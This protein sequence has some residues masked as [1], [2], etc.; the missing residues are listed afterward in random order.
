[1]M[2]QKAT[3]KYTIAKKENHMVEISTFEK[4][5]MDA[6]QS[7]YV[8]QPVV[9]DFLFLALLH[10]TPHIAHCIVHHKHSFKP[11][12]ITSLRQSIFVR[13]LSSPIL[14]LHVTMG[15]EDDLR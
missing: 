8:T 9:N 7:P 6:T 13:D 3:N 2:I 14:C 1:M 4:S 10:C 15:T 12:R 11:C 5:S